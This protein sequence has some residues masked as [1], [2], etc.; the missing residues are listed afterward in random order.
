MSLG[1][2]FSARAPF[3][4]SSLHFFPLTPFTFLTLTSPSSL[5]LPHSHFTFIAL[6]AALSPALK[7]ATPL[8]L[9]RPTLRLCCPPPFLLQPRTTI[10]GERCFCSS[11]HPCNSFLQVRVLILFTIFNK[12]VNRTCLLVLSLRCSTF[13]NF[14]LEGFK[15]DNICIVN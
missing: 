11:S 9:A 13:G 5:H 3:T 12:F 4:L 15:L 1:V 2:F 10:E 7:H 14:D 8:T 6:G